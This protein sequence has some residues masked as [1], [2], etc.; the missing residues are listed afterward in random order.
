MSIGRALAAPLDP[1]PSI[2]DRSSDVIAALESYGI[3]DYLAG[4]LELALTQ[5]VLPHY[6]RDELVE[7]VEKVAA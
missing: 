4:S 5:G 1:E 2:W 6:L 3:P 7:M